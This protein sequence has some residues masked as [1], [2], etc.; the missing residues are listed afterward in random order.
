MSMKILQ[1]NNRYPFPLA[2]NCSGPCGFRG[3]FNARYCEKG[4]DLFVGRAGLK[5]VG[6]D[7]ESLSDENA[8]SGVN[9]KFV[10]ELVKHGIVL[11][12]M[13]CGVLVFGCRR[14]F[15]M[16]GVSI[17]LLRN[18][19]PKTLQVLQVFKDQGLILA[20]LLGLSA[21][22]SMAETSITTLWP[23]KVLE[24]AEKDS[25][26]GVFKTLRSDVTQFLTTILIGTTVVN[27]GA[28]ALVTEAATTIFGEAGV[29]AATGVKTVAI[30]LLTEI[31]PKSIAVHNATEVARF[32]V[33]PVAWLSL[34]LYPVG[35]VVT[36][37]SMG[38]LK[39]LG[40]K[41]ISEPY[42]TEDELKLMLRG[43]E[44][45]GAIEEE[46][47]D[48]IENV[49]EIKDTHVRE[50]MK[51]LVDV[52][53]ID[54]SAILIDFH[55]LVPVFEQRVDNIVGIAYAM[56]LLDYAQKNQDAL[57]KFNYLGFWL[58]MRGHDGEL[59]SHLSTLIF[60]EDIFA[61]T[62]GNFRRLS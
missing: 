3:Y 31:T 25:E 49:L 12:A 29:S 33:R 56:D 1:R 53:A 46:E 51:P 14:V 32:V 26:N 28:T 38:M 23:W 62:L 42:V 52:V 6:E 13:V 19:W 20:A 10:R 22:F 48:M 54:A 44:L 15:A 41:G 11:A 43:A 40:L 45:S 60:L 47:Q 7:S 8:V 30:L 4:K 5:F 57:R 17:L 16:E 24:L 61:A 34:V 2:L 50:V 35:R 37:L 59:T 21:F 36:Y 9:L 18:A 27:I 58:D 55:T 39:I